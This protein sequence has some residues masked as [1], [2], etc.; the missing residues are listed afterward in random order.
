[1]TIVIAM[2]IILTSKLSNVNIN[3]WLSPNLK[4]ARTSDFHA[5]LQNFFESTIEDRLVEKTV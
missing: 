2:V 3:D 1:M 4:G 5:P